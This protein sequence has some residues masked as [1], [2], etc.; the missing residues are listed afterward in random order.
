MGW[1]IVS[2]ESH[3]VIGRGIRLAKHFLLLINGHLLLQR[4]ATTRFC[5][6]WWRGFEVARDLEHAWLQV[7]FSQLAAEEHG[8]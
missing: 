5:Q 4:G 8:C 3:C 6:T 1:L 2:R 7:R